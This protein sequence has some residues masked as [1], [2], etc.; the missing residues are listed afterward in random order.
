MKDNGIELVRIVKTPIVDGRIFSNQLARGGSFRAVANA[1]IN[2]WHRG[3][4]IDEDIRE[5]EISATLDILK[6]EFSFVD[7]DKVYPMC[8]DVDPEDIA[9][10]A[11]YGVPFVEGEPATVGP[12]LLESEKKFEVYPVVLSLREIRAYLKIANE[13]GYAYGIVRDQLLV[14]QVALEKEHSAL[15]TEEKTFDDYLEPTSMILT[16]AQMKAGCAEQRDDV[17]LNVL[18]KRTPEIYKRLSQLSQMV[19]RRQSENPIINLY[20][21]A[22]NSFSLWKA[23][24]RVMYFLEAVEDNWVLKKGYSFPTGITASD[25]HWTK[26]EGLRLTFAFHVAEI[27]IRHPALCVRPDVQRA[28]Q[29][30]I[31]KENSPAI[32]TV[33]SDAQQFS[34]V[35]PKEAQARLIESR[36]AFSIGQPSLNEIIARGMQL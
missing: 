17:V 20:K 7:I 21:R 12:A 16:G 5:Q 30:I 19:V 11:Q 29:K 14:A 25:F 18:F 3:C 32:R 33:L 6:A 23:R 2:D 27:L 13:I 35:N 9:F 22:S 28:I 34:P 15:L 10:N 4:P 8:D 31:D 1:V 36:V 26:T 24:R